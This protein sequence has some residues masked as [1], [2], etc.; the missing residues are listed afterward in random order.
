MNLSRTRLLAI[1]LLLGL[2]MFAGIWGVTEL[3]HRYG[4][5][6]GIVE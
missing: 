5:T 3:V 4:D 6:A 2:G 1:I